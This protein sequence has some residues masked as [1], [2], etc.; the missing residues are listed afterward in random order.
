[1]AVTL[2]PA[3]YKGLSTG[4]S[5]HSESPTRHQAI[6]LFEL[7]KQRLL[8]VNNWDK[9]CGE[10]TAA[11][12]LTDKEGNV[13]RNRQPQ[14]GDFI[15]IKLPAPPN[16][17]GDGYDWVRIEE[18]ENSKD[19]LKDEEIFGFRVRP[20]YNPQDPGPDPAHFYKSTATSTFLIVR[21]SSMVTALERGRNEVP[22]SAPYAIWNKLRNFAVAIGAWFGLAQSQWGKLVKGFIKG[23]PH[24]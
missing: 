22:N 8:D 7:A 4:A 12:Q 3:Q 9:L 23:P 24:S 16:A 1:M 13:I 21:T 11:F 14:I 15:R 19:L 5:T 10:V 17:E 6:L 18:F 20:V 2:I